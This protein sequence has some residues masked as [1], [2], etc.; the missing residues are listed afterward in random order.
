M[1]DPLI[2]E[3]AINGWMT[4]ETNPH[5]PLSADE[6]IASCTACF[7][8]G[9]Q[10]IHAHAGDAF[11]GDV[12]RH[13]SKPYLDAFGP[14]QRAYPD[15]ILYPTLP[16]GGPDITMDDRYAHMRELLA[17]GLLK[18][19]PIDPG[20]MN[21]GL[22]DAGGAPKPSDTIYQNT[23]NDVAYSFAFCRDNALISTLSIFEPGFLQLVLAHQRGGNL[24][25]ATVVK[26]E[27]SDG[28]LIYGLPAS[29]LSLDAYLAMLEGSGIPWM[30]NLRQGDLMDGFGEI[31]IARGG[32]VRVGIED[33][34]GNRI[35]RNEELVAEIVALG[36]RL[37][38]PPARHD[39]V[40]SLLTVG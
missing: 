33:Y 24:P 39:E 25:K 35:P 9:A 29:A 13:E 4:K 10:I 16:G 30:V 17:A 26:L 27:F 20:T 32:H 23:V 15:A 28:P 8:A 18:M 7:E 12:Q 38:R 19:A 21:W 22:R 5:I 14:V 40:S 34:G 6:V 11:V 36:H 1:A 31:A 3:V 2:V 37:G